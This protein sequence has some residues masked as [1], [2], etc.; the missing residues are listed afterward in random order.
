MRRGAAG[1]VGSRR[2]RDEIGRASA[3]AASQRL[4]EVDGLRGLAAAFV[5][6]HH[7]LAVLPPILDDTHA[8]GVTALNVVKYSPLGVLVAGNQLPLLFFLVSGFVLALPF[9]NGR[10]PDFSRF[11]VKRV[12]RIWPA[13]AVAC[14]LAFLAAGA[15][16]GKAIPSL[17]RWPAGAWQ[18]PVTTRT[19]AQ[20]LT[21]VTNFPTNGFDPAIWSLVHEL[22]VSLLF[23]LLA[24]LVLWQRR[25]W[26]T[27]AASVAVA[28]VALRVMPPGS[29]PT[30]Y[31]RTVAYLQFFVVGI[32][33][34][35]Y[36]VAVI[37][38]LRATSTASRLALAAASLVLYTFPLW[39][40]EIGGDTRRFLDLETALLGAT[41]FLVLAIGVPLAGAALRT[42]QA[43]HLGRVSYS[44]YLVHT[45]VLLALLHLFH[46]HA[47]LLLL[48][49]ALWPLSLGLAT[50]GERYIERPSA[51]LGRRLTQ[52][53]A[54]RSRATTAIRGAVGEGA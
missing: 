7:S 30:S 37:D 23:P 41:G 43:Q 40:P 50:L 20:H 25:W 8:Q 53:T 54:R 3:P 27:V 1:V 21:L 32:V 38:R 2:P 14:L 42:R 16:G 18:S 35:R 45:I 17:S 11:V 47:P 52:R 39:M 26:L 13:Y 36:R 22:R 29:G 12:I 28:Y 44:L 6:L 10:A 49:L 51:A 5:V 46:G 31:V 9:V 24:A 4:P 33:L 34:A 15:I 19:V 48:L